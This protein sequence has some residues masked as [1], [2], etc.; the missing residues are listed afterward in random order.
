[1]KSE[2]ENID[3]F[4]TQNNLSPVKKM[5]PITMPEDIAQ[6]ESKLLI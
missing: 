1:M 4:S 2:L 5:L 6:L 3:N